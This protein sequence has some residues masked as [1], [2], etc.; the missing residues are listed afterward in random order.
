MKIGNSLARFLIPALFFFGS[1]TT[2]DGMAVI[3]DDGG[4]ID[5]TD[6]NGSGDD[7]GSGI[8]SGNAD[9]NDFLITTVDESVVQVDAN[10][11]EAEI[12]YTFAD[13]TD[14]EIVADYDNGLI[15]V[16]TDDNAVNAIDPNI[17]QLVWDTPMLDYKFSSLGLTEPVCIDGV[18]YASG[19][20]GV[21]VALD[22]DTGDII[23]YFS[24]DPDGELDNVL[25]ENDTPIIHEN[26]VYVFYRHAGFSELP[27]KLFILNRQTGELLEQYFL[28][29][30]LS[31]TPLIVDNTLYVPAKNLYAL[32]VATLGVKWSF[33]ADGVGDP[34]VSNGRLVV[35]GVP[36]DETIY[37]RTYC[38]DSNSGTLLWTVDSGFDTLY[39]PIIV[40]NVVFGVYEEGS[41]VP[42][43]DSGRPFAVRLSDGQQ[44]WFRDDVVVD[45]SPVYANGR[46][47]FHGHDINRTD[48]TEL[49][50]GLFCMDA[51]TGE[52]IWL[53][54]LVD[55]LRPIAPLVVAQN[56]IF[57]P[58]YYRGN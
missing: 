21:V 57:G 1:C 26:K 47:F 33:E 37:S 29:Y 7:D 4:I 17:K 10:S 12:L 32:D 14:I 31:G 54:Y 27:P 2:D 41:P 22:Q 51:N 8:V 24:T 44:I 55:G 18:C 19:Q 3:D 16:T 25:N 45:N 28:D 42:F 34:F 5:N 11:G 6:D 13:L 48:D 43:G 52:I 46:L 58:S 38:L 9:F 20:S 15:F 50:T 30:E 40:E 49:N 56:G 53:N 23:W 39:A 35:Q 36:I